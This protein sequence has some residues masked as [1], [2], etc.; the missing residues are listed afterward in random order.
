MTGGTT[1]VVSPEAADADQL[2]KAQRFIE[3]QES[4]HS[5]YPVPFYLACGSDEAGKVEL[6]APVLAILK[7]VIQILGHGQSISV[8]T[9][10]Q[11]ISTQ[12]A[13]AILGVSRPTVVK[14]I[15]AG[16]LS[17]RVPGA[18]RRRLHLS[19]VLAYC[20]ALRSRRDRF[21]A[22][23]AAEY[24]DAGADDVEDLLEQ[25]RHHK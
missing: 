5:S 14:L 8:L 10:G 11:E 16:E 6:T 15:D 13:A 1:I 17:A 22:E 24:D 3:A 9:R 21:I 12:Q 19:E 2:A 7:Q 4:G 18:A 25:A 20:D 23:S